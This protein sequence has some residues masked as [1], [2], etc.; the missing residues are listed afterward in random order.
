MSI[1]LEELMDSKKHCMDIDGVEDVQFS[2][3]VAKI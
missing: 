1:D 3:V 2:K